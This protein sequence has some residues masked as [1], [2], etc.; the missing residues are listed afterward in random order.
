V[1][2]PANVALETITEGEPL[3]DPNAALEAMR[4]AFAS[5]GRRLVGDPDHVDDLLT[6]AE[7]AQ[8]LDEWLSAG[9]FLPAAWAAA[10]VRTTA[11][12]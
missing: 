4:D 9:G 5:L 12:V 8:A 2:A 11:N 1:S 3:M 6:I 10:D 7:H